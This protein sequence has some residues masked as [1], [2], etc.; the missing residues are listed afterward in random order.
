MVCVVTPKQKEAIREEPD[1]F[2]WVIAFMRA[3]SQ[4]PRE[5]AYIRLL[6]SASISS[7]VQSFGLPGRH[8][9]L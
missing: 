2:F 6:N 1:G 7:T 3:S 5:P 8:A 9:S 4:F